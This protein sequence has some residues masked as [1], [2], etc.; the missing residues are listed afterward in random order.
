MTEKESMNETMRE[1]IVSLL[2]SATDVLLDVAL[3][4]ERAEMVE[5]NKGVCSMARGV[6][7]LQAM[8]E[9]E[10]ENNDT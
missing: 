6:Q 4:P 7:Q 10:G 1:E 8:I 9:T 3:Y 2:K 5:Y